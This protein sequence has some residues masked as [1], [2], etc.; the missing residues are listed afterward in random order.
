MDPVIKSHKATNENTGN[1]QGVQH[2]V[3]QLEL[4]DTQAEAIP[5]PRFELLSA[6]KES[7]DQSRLAVEKLIAAIPN[8]DHHTLGLLGSIF[9]ELQNAQDTIGQLRNSA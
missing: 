3:Q 2:L 4:T 6:A 7:I 9:A 8:N 1:E 5:V